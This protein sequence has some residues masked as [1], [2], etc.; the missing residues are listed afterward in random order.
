MGILW[1]DD[2]WQEYLDWQTQD[3]KTLR[4]INKLIKDIQR[5][6]IIP[7]NEFSCPIKFTNRDTINWTFRGK[8]RT[9]GLEHKEVH[10]GRI[11]LYES[12]GD[13]YI[14]NLILDE[15]PEQD[16]FYGK[17][18]DLRRDYLQEHRPGLWMVLVNSGKL[19][20]H[21]KGVERM[22]E[23]RMDTLLP[24]LMKV[25]GGNRRIESQ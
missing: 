18:G 13:Y 15:E 4:R 7:C 5:C 20:D 23:Q 22:A 1:E 25:A 17:Y 10:Y 21:L 3:K 16:V 11:N 19:A 9:M 24:Q 12:R 2:A 6:A 8:N 14:P